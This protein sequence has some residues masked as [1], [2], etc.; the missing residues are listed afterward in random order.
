MLARLL[1]LLSI[2]SVAIEATRKH[3]LD[4]VNEFAKSADMGGSKMT[5]TAGQIAAMY[6]A[7]KRVH[8]GL[9]ARAHALDYLIRMGVPPV[10]GADSIQNFRK[11]RQGERYTRTLTRATTAYFLL[12]LS[13]DFPE[14]GLVNALIALRAHIEYLEPIRGSTCRQERALYDEFFMR[15]PFARAP[16]YPDEVSQSEFNHQKFIEGATRQVLVNRYER[17]ANARSAC[18]Q[19]WGMVCYVCSFDFQKTYGELGRGFIHVHHLTD[20]ASV[21][22]AYE[23]DPHVDL[24]PVCPNCH[25]MLH[26]QRP[27]IDIEVLKAILVK[28]AG[29]LLSDEDR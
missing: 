26:T 22:A 8:E 15:L 7:A 16:I 19:H 20:I 24:R 14:D 12:H 23:V 11:M 18:I 29:N 10:Q 13:E 27:A 5:L 4:E 2:Q 9:I 1:H 25:A 21:G 3:Q 6:E 17:D 28:R